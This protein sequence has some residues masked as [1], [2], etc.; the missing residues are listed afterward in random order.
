M[1]LTAT[2]NVRGFNSQPTDYDSVLGGEGSLG[3]GAAVCSGNTL[4]H[5]TASCPSPG[6]AS[7]RRRQNPAG[8]AATQDPSGRGTR[9]RCSRAKQPAASATA[10]ASARPPCDLSGRQSQP[11]RCLQ[12]APLVGSVLAWWCEAVSAPRSRSSR[13][14]VVLAGGGGEWCCRCL[15]RSLHVQVVLGERENHFTSGAAEFLNFKGSSCDDKLLSAS[16]LRNLLSVVSTCWDPDIVLGETHNTWNRSGVDGAPFLPRQYKP[17]Q[18]GGAWLS[19]KPEAPVLRDPERLWDLVDDGLLEENPYLGL[20]KKRWLLLGLAVVKSFRKLPQ[21]CS[22]TPSSPQSLC[23][24]S[25]VVQLASN[26]SIDSNLRRTC[27][28]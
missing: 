28:L 13:G 17:F 22:A 18:L 10:R 3:G 25:D 23:N 2:P 5:S 21:S 20:Y 19:D 15:G 12:P 8:R 6:T 27:R 9:H 26:L 16:E 4:F 1:T 14:R 24:S 7:Q 11:R